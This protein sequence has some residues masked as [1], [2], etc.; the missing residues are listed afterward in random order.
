MRFYINNI[1]YLINTFSTIGWFFFYLKV[2]KQYSFNF[3]I[4]IVLKLKYNT[5][6]LL[7]INLK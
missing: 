7:K 6:E 5:C 2:L 1:A 4:M 3:V